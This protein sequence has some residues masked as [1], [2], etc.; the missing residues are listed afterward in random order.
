MGNVG[1]VIPT[2]GN[3]PLLT[4]CVRSIINKTSHKHLYFYIAD[5]GST[6]DEINELV[7]FLKE[8]LSKERIKLIRYDWYHFGKINNDV[9]FKHV[10]DFI[11]HIL[12]CNNDIELIDDCITPM[13][14]VSC[15]DTVGTVGCKLLYG[16][17]TIQ[18]GGQKFYFRP[19]PNKLDFMV[20]HRGLKQSEDNFSE[21]DMVFGNTCGFCMI[22]KELFKSF[23]G[24]NT[25]YEECFEDVELNVR[26]LLENL[27]NVYLGNVKA[28]HYE[29]QTRSNSRDKL[30]RERSDFYNKLF[31]FL[32]R[33]YEKLGDRI[34]L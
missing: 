1:I 33:A 25:I 12:F 15:E 24:F 11:D 5:T 8:N 16:D 23:G 3:I 32:V 2:K 14:K 21:I 31:P 7:K 9:I 19:N 26:C 30:E 34:V 6:E 10:D 17:N 22:K 4:A 29:S 18:H 27:D 13:V 20:T 28:Y